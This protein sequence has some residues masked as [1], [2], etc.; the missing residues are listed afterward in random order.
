MNKKYVKLL[1]YALIVIVLASA[2]FFLANDDNENTTS[3]TEYDNEYDDSVEILKVEKNDISAIILN[4]QGVITEILPKDE[5]KETWVIKGNENVE[6]NNNTVTSFAESV[7][8]ISAT[9]VTNADKNLAQYGLDKNDKSLNV[10]TKDASF[11][12]YLGTA[13]PDNSYYYV[14]KADDN[15]VYMLSSV[16]G[17]RFEYNLNNFVDKTVAQVSPYKLHNVE[18][19]AKGKEDIV[20]E[21]NRDKQGN[22]QNLMAM[23]METMNMKKPY[24][25]VAVYPNNLQE[26]VLSTF[27]SFELGDIVSTSLDESEKFGF[28][29]PECK[30]YLADDTNKFNMTVGK[31]ADDTNYYCTVNDKNVIFLVDEKFV[32]P[33]I[34][35]KPIDFIEKFVALNYRADVNAVNMTYKGKNYDVTFGE[36]VKS[37]EDENNTDENTAKSRF[38]DDRKTFINKKELN[39]DE[40]ADFFELLVGITFEKIDQTAKAK[41]NVPE[42]TIKYTMKDGTSQEI[43]FNEFN[44]SFYLVTGAKVD[45]MLVSKQT[46]HRVFYKADEFLK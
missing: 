9:E 2:Y 32:N 34:N 29:S 35:A 46:V 43:K 17:K 8:N 22:A 16:N 13:T 14:K 7:S 37:E 3:E 45:G 30:V 31:K 20:I 11:T 15:T 10:K 5:N 27:T 44:D 38:K 40:F 1:I 19:K 28:N 39:K 25:N 24:A 12:L 4:N 26:K 42:V 23:G 33:F 41:T 6:L 21:Y 36:E 18:I